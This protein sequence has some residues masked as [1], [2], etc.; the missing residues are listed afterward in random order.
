MLLESQ[1]CL[2]D[3]CAGGYLDFIFRTAARE[4]FDQIVPPGQ[5]HMRTL[6]NADFQETTLELDGQIKL[7]FALAYGFRNIQTLM[8]KIKRRACEYHYIE[9]MACPSGCLNGGGQIK[10]SKSQTSTQFLDHLDRVY[11]GSDVQLRP[12]QNNPLVDH[13]YRV[14]VGGMPGSHQARQLL[15]TCY[16]PRTKPLSAAVGDW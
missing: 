6:R 10:A 3:V 8:R 2:V 15:H 5:L 11:H 16:H 14:W 7:R 1:S 13:L 12:P 4:L 9:I